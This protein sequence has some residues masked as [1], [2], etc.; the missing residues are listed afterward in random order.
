MAPDQVPADEVTHADRSDSVDRILRILADALQRR[1]RAM[2][3]SLADSL[4]DAIEARH[5]LSPQPLAGALDA[6]HPVDALPPAVWRWAAG[7]AFAMVVTVRETAG[8]ARVREP[9]DVA[10]SFPPTE[11][12]HPGREVRVA[13][14][15]DTPDGPI[16]RHVPSQVYAEG[17][18]RGAH[19]RAHAR[20]AWQADVGPGTQATYV[21]FSGNPAA[22]HPTYPTDLTVEGEG[23]GLEVAND[24]YVASLHPQ[25]GQLQRLRF[26]RAHGF[27]LYAGGEGHGEPPHI[28]WAHDYLASGRF[29]KFRVT[30]WESVR[31]LEVVRGPVFTSVRRF[32]FPT[33]PVHPLFIGARMLV[34]VE[35]RFHAGLP[36]F[37]KSGRM[38]AAQAF[39]LNYL[40]DDEWVFSG[41]GFTRLAWIDRDGKV[42][43]GAVPPEE[44]EEM[45]GTGFLNPESHD[46]FMSIRLDHRLELAS[47]TRDGPAP[48]LRHADA[49]SLSYPGHGQLWSRWA[50]RGDPRL[51][52]GDRLVQRNAYLTAPLDLETL[53]PQV[54]AWRARLIAPVVVEAADPAT[55]P[56]HLI[57]RGALA[58]PGE[59]PDARAIKAGIWAASRATRDDMLYVMDANLAD[60]GYVDDIRMPGGVAAGD[61]EIRLSMPHR[62]RPMF[63]YLGDPLAA[64]VR[65]IPGVRSV[66]VIPAPSGAWGAHRISARTWAAFG[67][68]DIGQ[69]QS[70]LAEGQRE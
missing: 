23:A 11:G 29:Q 59:V 28:D 25:T 48:T 40:R 62:G 14:V 57:T 55:I 35:Y 39:S 30:N 58:S 4:K 68:E 42:H 27:E 53:A 54:G 17:Q 38:E 64:R 22:E 63:R 56:G 10:V 51:A 52:A 26:R 44:A 13:A 66:T 9:V 20:V 8:L 43:I 7:W 33:S 15:V 60:M 34:D 2:A 6:W 32:G 21:L 19:G 61:I 36:Y 65:Q 47:G 1:D 3:L 18:T 24:N 46:A 50:L 67:F 41:Y 70:D 31:N 16:L 49:P 12:L 5:L 45:W 37:T 69:G